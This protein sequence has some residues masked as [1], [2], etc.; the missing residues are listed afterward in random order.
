[1][2]LCLY[3]VALLGVVRVVE[4]AV[5]GSPGSYSLFSP[6]HSNNLLITALASA[7][8]SAEKEYGTLGSAKRS[9]VVLKFQKDIDVAQ[10]LK[11]IASSSD[12]SDEKYRKYILKMSVML[13]SLRY[14]P[15]GWSNYTFRVKAKGAV[16]KG[17]QADGSLGRIEFMS[18]RPSQGGS[19][20]GSKRVR[21]QFSLEASGEGLVLVSR[22]SSVGLSQ[23]KTELIADSLEH[24]LKAQ[25][26]RE[27]DLAG[28][29][30]RQQVSYVQQ[31][32]VAK[33]ARKAKEIDK[34][35]RPEKYKA[36]SPTVR[37]VGS[38][39]SGSGRYA[40]SVDT[41]KRREVK[42]R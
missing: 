23:R 17:K 30:R 1:M 34:I 9:D 4:A 40:P 10:I 38:G 26:R 41:K 22:S 36:K 5:V 16:K 13:L 18:T 19:P 33:K 21:V 27:V 8:A 35:L 20:V 3:I 42:S 32:G 11:K 7:E 6:R 15:F 12:V 14:Y 28:V 25:L 37:S 24:F 39:S 2:W 29:R 31:A